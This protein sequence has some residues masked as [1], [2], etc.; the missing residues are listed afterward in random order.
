MLLPLQR[1]DQ[2]ESASGRQYTAKFTNHPVGMQHVLQ[3]DD[4]D[5]RVKRPIGEG[6]SL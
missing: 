4:V 1:C 6:K 3:R 2:Q 5:G